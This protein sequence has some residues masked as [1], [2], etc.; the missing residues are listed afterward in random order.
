M[1]AIQASEWG[2]TGSAETLRR[3]ALSAGKSGQPAIV[4]P[5]PLA[6]L[7]LGLALGLGEF[8]FVGAAVGGRWRRCRGRPEGR[9]DDRRERGRRAH[10]G[11]GRSGRARNRGQRLSRGG[12]RSAMPGGSQDAQGSEA[13]PSPTSRE[14]SRS[15]VWPAG[16]QLPLPRGPRLSP[17]AP[18]WSSPGAA[19]RRRVPGEVP[20][21]RR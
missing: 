14:P 3:Q 2:S 13:A 5:P 12:S 21:S 10:R 6:A 20:G 1:L 17:A 18:R 15:P 9:C 8:R 16:A 7:G 4:A 19:S 11:H